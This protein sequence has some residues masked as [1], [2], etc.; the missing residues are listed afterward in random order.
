[1]INISEDFNI[2]NSSL[3]F[4]NEI[5]LLHKAPYEAYIKTYTTTYTTW[6]G[7]GRDYRRNSITKYHNIYIENFTNTLH[8]QLSPN[9]EQECNTENNHTVT[10]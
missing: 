8:V 1:M 2:L 6:V 10:H 3:D 5:T 9:L 4:T 7:T